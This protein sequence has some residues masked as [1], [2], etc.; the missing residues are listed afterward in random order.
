MSGL[1]W[2]GVCPSGSAISKSMCPGNGLERFAFN[3]EGNLVVTSCA[4]EVQQVGNVQVNRILVPSYEDL[5]VRRRLMRHFQT[6]QQFL[7]GD[8]ILI[9]EVMAILV[10]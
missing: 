8:F 7:V 10:D 5:R 9:K 2:V 6:V 4:N 1:A 3:F